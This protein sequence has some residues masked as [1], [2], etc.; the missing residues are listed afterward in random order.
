MSLMTVGYFASAIRGS[1]RKLVAALGAKAR[2]GRNGMTLRALPFA[3][4]LGCV[5]A[6]IQD[7]ECSPIENH[8]VAGEAPNSR[9]RCVASLSLGMVGVASRLDRDEHSGKPDD[10]NTDVKTPN[11]LAARKRPAG[12]SHDMRSD[13]QDESARGQ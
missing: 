11:E 13:A 3:V 8:P 6:G 9:R 5:N 12:E 7:R 4:E 1:L 10:E 2:G